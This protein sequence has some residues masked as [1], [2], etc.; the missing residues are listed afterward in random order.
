MGKLLLV[1]GLIIAAIGL[2]VMLGLPLG[3]LPGDITLR[4]GNA[5]FYFPVVTSILLSVLLSLLFA[6]LRR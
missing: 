2:L 5:T 4:R 3:R 1:S 6:F